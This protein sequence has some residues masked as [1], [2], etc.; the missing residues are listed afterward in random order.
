MHVCLFDIDGTLIK[1]G[2]AGKAAIESALTEEFGVRLR[3]DV[4]YSGRTDRAIGRDLFLL[5]GIE[6]T[7]ENWQRLVAGYLARLPGC[8][9]RHPGRV[10]HGITTLLQRL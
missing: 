4:P 7:P 9:G 5:H 3:G 10:M 8:L 1:S 6:A 2:G